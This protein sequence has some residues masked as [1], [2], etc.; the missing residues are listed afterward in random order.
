MSEHVRTAVITAAIGLAVVVGV[1]LAMRAGFKGYMARISSSRTPQ[2]LAGQRTR[3][4]ILERVVTVT[5][6]AIVGWSVLEVFP[7]TDAL[8]RSLLA[9]GA[10]LA[11]LLGIALSAPLSNMGS[12]VL[13]GWSQSVRLGDRVTVADVTGTAV[14][15]TLMQTVLVTDEGRRVFIPNSQ[16]ASSIVTNRS[17]D[18]PRRVVS[19]RLPIAVTTPVEEARKAVLA[20]VEGFEGCSAEDVTVAR[21]RRDG[22]DGV[23]RAQRP[24][25]AG[26]R[27][28]I[29]RRRPPRAGARPRSSRPSCCPPERC[30]ARAWHQHGARRRASAILGATMFR[31]RFAPSPTGSLHVGNAL[32]GVETLAA[33]SDEELAERADAPLELVPALRGAR[34]LN[35]ARDYAR[36]ILSPEE[37]QVP[38]TARPTLERFRELELANGN[39]HMVV[40]EL[41]AVGG[42]LKALRLA[43]TGRDRGPE[44]AT[45]IDALPRDEALRRIDAA[46]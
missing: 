16:M 14:E 28:G 44:L 20:A 39:G 21:H 1:R 30:Q 4:I 5:L 22:V 7:S 3:F 32:T 19:V 27:R 36:L 11:L 41:K 23:A 29:G 12:G 26:E 24:P 34:D 40:R 10:V 13:L 6:L 38:D 15:I 17:I 33:M 37:V 46:L 8:A 25:S 43:L 42:D 2:E 18:D 35:E 9:S 31:V 45:I